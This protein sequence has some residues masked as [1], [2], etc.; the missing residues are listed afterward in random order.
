M[1]KYLTHS[2]RHDMS[3]AEYDRI[4]SGRGS[5][6]HRY[7]RC[8]WGWGGWRGGTEISCCHCTLVVWVSIICILF[9][10]YIVYITCI[11]IYILYTVLYCVSSV[12]C[13]IC[14]TYNY[15]HVYCVV[16]VSSNFSSNAAAVSSSLFFQAVYLFH[17]QY[18]TGILH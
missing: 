2:I 1:D 17:H 15:D 14:N 9:T 6:P 7:W 11:I 16:S 5:V 8:R 10:L 12:Y 4:P 13:I 3:I 18:P